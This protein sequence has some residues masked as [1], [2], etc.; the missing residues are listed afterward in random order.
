[1]KAWNTLAA[2]LSLSLCFGVEGRLNE[3]GEHKQLDS[4]HN[5]EPVARRSEETLEG[6]IWVE[7]PQETDDRMTVVLEETTSRLQALR[8]MYTPLKRRQNIDHK[9]RLESIS[10]HHRALLARDKPINFVSRANGGLNFDYK[11][12]LQVGLG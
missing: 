6:L 1:M 8:G 7:L 11:I 3:K 2:V 12:R 10:E 5:N 9:K 4:N